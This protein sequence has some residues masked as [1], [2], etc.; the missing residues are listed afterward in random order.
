MATVFVALIRHLQSHDS[1]SVFRALL[2]VGVLDL[3]R[4]GA[5]RPLRTVAPLWCS[6]W[7][8]GCQHPES[9]RVI[10]PE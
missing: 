4:V 10:C 9:V 6:I 5:Q 3:R 1:V 8:S 2:P 7:P